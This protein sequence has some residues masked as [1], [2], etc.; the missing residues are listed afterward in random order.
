MLQR[1]QNNEHTA[2]YGVAEIFQHP[3]YKPRTFN[4]DIALLRING[5]ISFSNK[6]YPVCLPTKQHVD[7]EVTVT[8]FGKTGLD[9]T[10]SDNLLKVGLESFS[11]D[12]CQ[13]LYREHQLNESTMVCYG[14]H[15]QRKD[16]CKVSLI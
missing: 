9:H 6:I 16:A 10:Q 3:E 12:D 1:L 8:G 13:R 11:F 7:P 14:H 15:T 5:M 4:N 2:T